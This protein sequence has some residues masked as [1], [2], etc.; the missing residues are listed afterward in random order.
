[1]IKQLSLL[2]AWGSCGLMIAMVVT[3]LYFLFFIDS[4]LSFAQS[5]FPI[6]IQWQT[7]VSWQLYSLWVVMALSAGLSVGGLFFLWRAFRGFADGQFFTDRNSRSLRMFAIFLFLQALVSPIRF[8][9]A[10]VILSANHPPG[11]KMLSI[12]LESNSVETIAYGLILWIVSELLI[13]ARKIETENRQ[14]V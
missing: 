12:S 2:I 3:G 11:Q 1:M 14:F 7:V 6:A 4:F 10:S 13:A 9:A 8:A 5:S